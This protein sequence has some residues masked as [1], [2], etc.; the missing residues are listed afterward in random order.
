M[1]DSSPNGRLGDCYI[2]QKKAEGE[3]DVFYLDKFKKKLSN[4]IFYLPSYANVQILYVVHVL[5]IH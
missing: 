3:R 4:D 1:L 5:L 2:I